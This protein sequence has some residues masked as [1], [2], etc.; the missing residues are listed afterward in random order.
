MLAHQSTVIFFELFSKFCFSTMFS[1][2]GLGLELLLE[3][4]LVL[5]LDLELGLGLGLILGL[6]FFGIFFTENSMCSK[7]FQLPVV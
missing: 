6:H 4:G 2:L 5:G 7:Y 1:K 3:L